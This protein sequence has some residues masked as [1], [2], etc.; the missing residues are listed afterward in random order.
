[1]SKNRSFFVRLTLSV[2]VL[3]VCGGA[4]TLP[5]LRGVDAVGSTPTVYCGD[6]PCIEPLSISCEEVLQKYQFQGSC[7]SLESIPETRGCRLRVTFG[8]CIWLPICEIDHYVQF[9]DNN[10][11]MCNRHY[12]TEANERPCPRYDYDAI[13]EQSKPNW[14]PPSCA[15]SMAPATIE[16]GS[17]SPPSSF[18]TNGAGVVAITAIFVFLFNAVAFAV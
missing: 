17:S 11:S 14:S 6:K 5:L 1:M 16:A 9:C 4:P 12:I 3:L 8:N 13:E 7:C 2:A 15:P 10:D 18:A